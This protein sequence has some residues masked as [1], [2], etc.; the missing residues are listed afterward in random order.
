[1]SSKHPDTDVWSSE[2]KHKKG[3]ILSHRCCKVEARSVEMFQRGCPGSHSRESQWDLLKHDGYCSL[4]N[5]APTH[6]S[7]PSS[8]NSY[9]LNKQINQSI[10]EW[11]WKLEQ[12]MRSFCGV[13]ENHGLEPSFVVLF[14]F[15]QFYG[16]N[17]WHVSLYMFKAYGMMV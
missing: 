1:M 14:C 2:E 4:G 13:S 9:L 3:N 17:N 16:V 6:A 7:S 10:H 12:H 5:P 8:I 15:S 11:A